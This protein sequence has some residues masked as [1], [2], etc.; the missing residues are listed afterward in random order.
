MRLQ[1]TTSTGRPS[2]GHLSHVCAGYISVAAAAAY[3]YSADLRGMHGEL[4]LS[5]STF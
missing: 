4:F 2:C 5:P 3:S 1:S